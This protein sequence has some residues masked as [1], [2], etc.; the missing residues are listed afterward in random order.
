[1]NIIALLATCCRAKKSKKAVFLK[2]LLNFKNSLIFN[3]KNKMF[4][5]L[6]N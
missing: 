4:K 6:K 3:R 1:M 2:H 5:T